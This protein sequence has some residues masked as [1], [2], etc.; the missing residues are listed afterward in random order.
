M[1]R[2]TRSSNRGHA[3]WL[4]GLV[5]TCGGKLTCLPTAGYRGNCLGRGRCPC[6]HGCCKPLATLVMLC[7]AL[8]KS[9]QG[10][11]GGQT[12]FNR[13]NLPRDPRSLAGWTQIWKLAKVL[14]CFSS[15]LEAREI[16]CF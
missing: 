10:V 3:A 1:R 9:V 13:H 12:V 2:F 4:L 11:G 16:S 5:I 7:P 14:E 8:N 6:A 15:H